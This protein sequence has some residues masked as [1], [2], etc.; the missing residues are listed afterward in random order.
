MITTAATTTM[1]AT[2]ATMVPV[3]T[4]ITCFRSDASSHCPGR[5]NSNSARPRQDR[6]RLIPLGPRHKHECM[7]LTALVKHAEA[8]RVLAGQMRPH[9]DVPRC[10]PRYHG[11]VMVPER[12]LNLLHAPDDAAVFLPAGQA[13]RL[14]GIPGVLRR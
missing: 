14:G 13:C 7:A 2:M 12:R 1:A 10:V 4:R 11:I 8:E 9:A 6:G 5:A 3:D